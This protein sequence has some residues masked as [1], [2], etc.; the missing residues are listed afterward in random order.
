MQLWGVELWCCHCNRYLVI[1]IVIFAVIVTVCVPL[2]IAFSAARV[3]T[4][5][6]L[7]AAVIFLCRLWRLLPSHKRWVEQQAC[8]MAAK[9]VSERRAVL[10]PNQLQWLLPG[11]SLPG[12]SGAM[13][14]PLYYSCAPTSFSAYDYYGAAPVSG[15]DAPSPPSFTHGRHLP[16]GGFAEPP[17]PLGMHSPFS[18]PHAPS[19]AGP[20]GCSPSR[21]LLPSSAPLQQ[22]VGDYATL[23]NNEFA[24]LSYRV[25]MSSRASSG[26]RGFMASVAGG[27]D[28]EVDWTQSLPLTLEDPSCVSLEGGS[29]APSAF[30]SRKGSLSLRGGHS[31]PLVLLS[32]GG[33]GNRSHHQRSHSSSSPDP[34]AQGRPSVSPTRSPFPVPPV[35]YEE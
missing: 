21:L 17:R 22:E 29:R 2:F 9:L 10:P 34:F 26:Q 15:Y 25:S 13:A 4:G 23:G 31:P 24:A 16:Y 28:A 33:S 14:V 5:I 27:G 30:C 11:S 3:Y 20:L 12:R 35:S 19:L 32:Q 6:L 18:S 1:D 8:K 7:G